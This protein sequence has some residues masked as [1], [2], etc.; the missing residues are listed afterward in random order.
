MAK[1]LPRRYHRVIPRSRWPLRGSVEVE[2]RVVYEWIGLPIGEMKFD[3]H[4][5]WSSDEHPDE[6]SR[7]LDDLEE[8]CLACITHLRRG[9][10]RTLPMR[11][12]ARATK[13]AEEYDVVR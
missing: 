9:L 6:L 12:G 2:E 7:S 5:S 1:D 13:L 10:L 11:L 4:A 3:A 8:D